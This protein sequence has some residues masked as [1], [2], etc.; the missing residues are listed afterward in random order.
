VLIRS[1]FCSDFSINLILRDL[2]CAILSPLRL[3]ATAKNIS[4]LKLC[5]PQQP[6]EESEVSSQ[7]RMIFHKLINTCVEN[8]IVQKYFLQ[9]SASVLPAAFSLF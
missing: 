3:F 2:C 9:S 6:V 8:L 1:V 5:K 7:Q 4:A